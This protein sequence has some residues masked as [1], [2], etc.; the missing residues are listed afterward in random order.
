MSCALEAAQQCLQLKEGLQAI[1]PAF[2][3]AADAQHFT[4]VRTRVC[5]AQLGPVP[6]LQRVASAD[7]SGG[8]SAS[9]PPS[10]APLPAPFHT[11]C[12]PT[13]DNRSCGRPPHR[14]AAA[15]PS[16]ATEASVLVGMPADG[17]VGLHQGLPPADRCTLLVIA[18]IQESLGVTKPPLLLAPPARVPGHL[19]L[20]PTRQR[21]R[22]SHVHAE[23][24]KRAGGASTVPAAAQPFDQPW[25]WRGWPPSTSP[26]RQCCRMHANIAQPSNVC[27]CTASK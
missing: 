20:P 14:S 9:C 27:V 11:A 22:R 25:R 1:A 5:R 2:I 23:C 15:S 17:R 12:T 8:H 18:T 13:L 4:Q 6:Q 19:P 10:I 7:A 21:R 26:S 3:P 24:L 16:A